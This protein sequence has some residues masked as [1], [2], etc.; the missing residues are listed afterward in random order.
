MANRHGERKLS[1]EGGAP[2]RGALGG[3]R[4]AETRLHPLA[5]V[6]DEE[7]LVG[8]KAFRIKARRVLSE[9]RVVIGW[10][11]DADDHRG[12]CVGGR[13][14]V[15]Q[16]LDMPATVSGVDDELGPGPRDVYGYLAA[17]VV[18]ERSGYELHV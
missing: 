15:T 16:A 11:V 5:D 1:P 18:F 13:E 6:A 8:R 14:S 10:A 2:N 4:Y 12:H 7:L 17:T 9:P 3:R